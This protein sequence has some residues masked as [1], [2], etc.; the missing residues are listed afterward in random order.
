MPM[1]LKN[2]KNIIKNLISNWIYTLWYIDFSS[3]KLLVEVAAMPG[4]RRSRE[5]RGGLAWIAARNM[6]MVLAI[7]FFTVYAYHRSM[8]SKQ[9]YAIALV[10][11]LCTILSAEGGIGICAY[12]GA[13]LFTLDQRPW[14]Q[15][16]VHILPFALLVVVWRVIYQLN[17]YGAAGMDLYV[18][19]GQ[20]PAEFLQRALWAYPAN[21][22]EEF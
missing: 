16:I 7:G 17:G 18:D 6:I 14:S 12:L 2:M 13:Y 9:W 1:S 22:F 20:S 11:L 4:V 21:Y 10:G 3:V 5:S 15:R 8:E 19:P